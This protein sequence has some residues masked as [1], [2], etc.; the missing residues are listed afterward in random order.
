METSTWLPALR[1]H[2]G[3]RLAIRLRPPHEVSVSRGKFHHLLVVTQELSSVT[4]DGMPEATYN[5][6]L[7]DLDCDLIRQLEIEGRVVLVETYR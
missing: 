6:S 4:A 1:E 5:S 3:Q 2:F 7:A